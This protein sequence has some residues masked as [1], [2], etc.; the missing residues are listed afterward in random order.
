MSVQFKKE[1]LLE[2]LKNINTVAVPNGSFTVYKNCKII[3]EKEKCTF[4]A[5]DSE[6][7]I[8][9]GCPFEEIKDKNDETFE[10]LI[11]AKQFLLII[12]TL[13]KESLIIFSYNNGDPKVKIKCNKF[14]TDIFS[15]DV[16]EFPKIELNDKSGFSI[17]MN[18]KELCSIVSKLSPC[19]S[20]DYTRPIFRGLC[21][22][23]KKFNNNE[24]LDFHFL[25]TNGHIL[26]K[27]SSCVKGFGDPLKEQYDNGIII[28][29]KAVSVVS[30]I[31][32]KNN[33]DLEIHFM[34]SHVVFK[35][36]NIVFKTTVIEGSFPKVDMIFSNFDNVTECQLVRQNFLDMLKRALIY[37]NNKKNNGKPIIIELNDNEISISTSDEVL[38]T[39]MDS[40]ECVYE[41]EY[42]KCGFNP[43]YIESMF[44]SLDEDVS[45][46]SISE[47][48]EMCLITEV[49]PL[50]I[51]FVVMGMNS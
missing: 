27:V 20:D 23:P 5:C 8:S 28:P 13:E 25:V 46:I 37:Y 36:E 18:A 11:D 15:Q 26:G 14:K 41:K 4:Q 48:N 24:D 43:K 34:N 22:C 2:V 35:T 21:F 39:M 44:N 3:K 51:K 45:S 32:S 50:D 47:E 30:K 40:M 16:Q 33:N 1:D 19:I 49:Q 12:Q 31:F 6:T 17:K 29:S 38:G 10:C 7:S 9:V 42:V